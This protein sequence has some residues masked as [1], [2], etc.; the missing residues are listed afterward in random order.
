M[1]VEREHVGGI[2]T[3]ISRRKIDLKVS[4]PSLRISAT[5]NPPLTRF[6]LTSRTRPKQKRSLRGTWFIT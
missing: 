4:K 5:H 6:Q 1:H 3:S 2:T